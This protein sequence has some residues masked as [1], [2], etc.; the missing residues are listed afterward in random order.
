MHRSHLL[1]NL[2]IAAVLVPALLADGAETSAA[3]P[4][5]YADHVGPIFKRHCGKCHGETV[6]KVGLDLSNYLS[7]L[8]GS[9]GGPVVVAGRPSRSRALD[10]ILSD[11]PAERM[12]LGGEPLSAEEIAVVT[13]WIREGLRETATSSPNLPPIV[14]FEP[15]RSGSTG[16]ATTF[17]PNKLPAVERPTLV[18]PFPVLALAA[19]PGSGY[20]AVSSYGVVNFV[21]AASQSVLG[22]IPF[23]GEPHVLRF[24]RDGSKLL[25][26]GG[27]PVEHGEVALFD[28][29]TG[30]RTA[31]VGNESDTVLAADLSSDQRLV[32]LGG[33]ERV[34]KIFSVADG[35]L[36]HQLVKHTDWITAL[37]FSPD[38]KLLATGD[39]V[40]NIYL[41]DPLTAQITLAL[42][43]HKGA[44]R[45]L[46]WRSDGKVLASCGEDGLIV[47][48]DAAKGAPMTS[49]ADAHT[50][51]RAPGE[52]G[53]IAGGVLDAEFSPR[54][55]LVTCGRDDTVR[56]WDSSGTLVKTF[57]ILDAKSTAIPRVRVYPLRV[58]VVGGNG[59]TIFA[60]DSAGKLHAWKASAK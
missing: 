31:T 39:R 9:N 55:E 53:K 51:P 2:L 24:S 42:S 33:P 49:Q 43:D 8:K 32:A 10:L 56:L 23:D 16:I 7:A 45:K 57:S 22:S 26:A 18:R 48:W 30:K 38:G 44:I 40:G 20:V 47:W 58:V 3:V 59:D 1:L 11:E 27:R 21:D 41:W 60:G 52:Y 6:H 4:V 5:N 14:D 36:V 29:A 25:V 15:A 34:V 35:K 19:V 13:T 17:E 28:L 50:R 54:G 46:N 12:P 37:A